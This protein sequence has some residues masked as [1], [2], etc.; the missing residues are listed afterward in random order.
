MFLLFTSTSYFVVFIVQ[1]TI[2]AF[3][4]AFRLVR[5][6]K[7]QT[8]V[9]KSRAMACFLA[10]AV[11]QKQPNIALEIIQQLNLKRYSVVIQ[12]IRLLAFADIERFHDVADILRYVGYNM[13]PIICSH[14]F[15]LAGFN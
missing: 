13:L 7:M 2:E 9:M 15:H 10:L 5:S 4:Q 11:N 8:R 3:D 12:S 1:N 14:L 6:V